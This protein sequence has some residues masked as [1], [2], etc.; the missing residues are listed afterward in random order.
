MKRLLLQSLALLGTCIVTGSALA[1]P[2][3]R[4]DISD[5]NP[6]LIYA[7]GANDASKGVYTL[8]TINETVNKIS[9]STYIQYSLANSGGTFVSKEKLYGTQMSGGSWFASYYAIVATAEGGS[10]GPWSHTYYNYRSP[11]FQDYTAMIVA[12]DMTYVA[13]EDKIY[14]LFRTSA[15]DDQQWCLATYDGDAVKVSKIADLPSYTILNAIAA[16]ATGE[17]YAINGTA[18]KLVK[19]D[20]TTA[21]ITEVGSLG[22]TATGNS[23]SAAIDPAS[24]K[25]YWVAGLNSYSTVQ[26]MYEVDVTTGVAKKLYD[27]GGVY[28]GLWI[29]APDTNKSAPAAVENLTAVFTGTGN[30]V[31][32]SFT[33]P[34]KTFGGATLSGEVDYTVNVD[35]EAVATGKAAA[36]SDVELTLAMAD[37]QHKVDVACSNASGAGAQASTS[38]FAGFDVPTNISDLKLELDGSKAAISWTAPQPANGGLLDESKLSYTVT[39]NPGNVVVATG[40]KEC[41][42]T[43]EIPDGFYSEYSWTVTVKYEGAEDQSLTTDGVMA[44]KPYTVPFSQDFN[45]VTNLGQAGFVQVNGRGDSPAWT[46]GADGDNKFAQVESKYYYTHDDYLFTAPIEMKAGVAYT[47]KFKLSSSAVSPNYW[48]YSSGTGVEKPRPFEMTVSLADKAA[49]DAQMTELKAVEYVAEKAGEPS[50][51]TAEFSVENDGTYYISFFDKSSYF[52]QEIALRVDDIEITSVVATPEA[53]AD[54]SVAPAEKGSRDIVVEF[55]APD[56][57]VDGNALASISAIDIYRGYDLI[58]T[59]TD[60]IAPGAKVTYTDEKAPRGFLAYGVVV[61]NGEKASAR[62]TASVMSG[63]LND[64]AVTEVSAPEF[65]K[66]DGMEQFKVTVFN[67]GA[68]TQLDYRVVLLADGMEVDALPGETIHTDESIVY[69]FDVKWIAT[70]QKDLTFNYSARIELN[71]DEKP[72]NN[73]SETYPIQFEYKEMSSI[74]D[75]DA[76]GV[77]VRGGQGCLQVEG[78]EGLEINV[79]GI[80]GRKVASSTGHGHCYTFN[81]EAGIYVVSAGKKAV[82]VAVY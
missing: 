12:K 50:E 28:G 23:Q 73:E 20:K 48:D 57:D 33:M 36:G 10:D 68:E 81:A 11:A 45:A 72:E 37:G 5:D 31:K 38:V 29:P 22:V 71:G 80:D 74:G 2:I 59:L 9:G 44:G 47:L 15:T 34:S 82:K 55:T 58:A 53:V 43:D 77:T 54:L 64:L 66:I 76:D 69:T 21:A 56:K 52:L 16:D 6:T 27:L 24:G 60:G 49:G 75:I 32:V 51:Y 1:A 17:L 40:L 25:M 79:Y 42:A 61:R 26:S 14:G 19:I 65:I 70:D 35:G 8:S 78:A 4:I 63:L 46:I 18:G 3:S 39:R 7:V 13:G 67:D 41:Q 30:D 62:T